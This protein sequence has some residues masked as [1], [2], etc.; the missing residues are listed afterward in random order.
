MSNEKTIAQIS[1]LSLASLNLF[2]EITEEHFNM[3][4]F[5]VGGLTKEQKGNLTD[6]KIKGL[7]TSTNDEGWL[8]LTELGEAFASKLNN[9]FIDD[10]P[11]EVATEERSR[12]CWAMVNEARKQDSNG[13]IMLNS[14]EDGFISDLLAKKASTEFADLTTAECGKI[15]SIDLIYGVTQRND[16]RNK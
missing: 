2:H 16:R 7:I 8:K 6:L 15:E 4:G 9:D 3:G 10:R 1:V 13:D 11:A 12:L 5:T 14:Q